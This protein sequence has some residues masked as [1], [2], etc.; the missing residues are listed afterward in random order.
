M[1]QKRLQ[2]LADAIEQL[3]KNVDAQQG[4]FEKL[5][6]D[7]QELNALRRANHR[8]REDLESE[9]QRL[10]AS[11]PPTPD[12]L[13]SLQATLQTETEELNNLQADQSA[14]EAEYRDL[15]DNQRMALGKSAVEVRKHFKDI[16]GTLL[17]EQCDLDYTSETRSI[18]QS[19]ENF[20]F[21]RFQVLMT[22]GVFRK[23][24]E[25]RTATSV[26]ESQKEYI[27]LAFRMAL[28][29]VASKKDAPAMLVLETPEASLDSYFVDRAGGLLRQFASIGGRDGTLVIATSN[30]NNETMIPSLLGLRVE[31]QAT[32]STAEVSGKLINLLTEAAPNAAL[33]A[34]RP[35]YET[36]LS[37]ALD[38]RS[39]STFAPR[40]SNR[41]RRAER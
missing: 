38:P 37:K 25:R 4:A 26:S 22:S 30:L 6:M 41:P 16:A 32:K 24:T 33:R 39:P 28:M 10:G 27:D 5:D 36:Q 9:L 3:K 2:I 15:L 31:S 7:Y 11:L 14:M 17:A 19:G 18:G 23:P 20:E 21:P 34:N 12:E 1:S 13:Q 40:K 8:E 29:T 35:F